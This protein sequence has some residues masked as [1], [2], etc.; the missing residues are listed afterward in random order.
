MMLRPWLAPSLFA[1]A[2]TACDDGSPVPGNEANR[3]AEAGAGPVANESGNVADQGA[4]P[5][6][7]PEA[8]KSRPSPPATPRSASGYRLIGTEPFWGGTVTSDEIVYSTPDNQSGEPIA[9]T[10]RF[11][12]DQEIYSGSLHGRPFVLTLTAGPRSDG[13]SDNVHAYT[14]TLEVDGETRRGCANPRA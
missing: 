3:Q 4:T 9:V 1:L 13:M 2:L 5:Q 12:G 8:P 6:P 11:E 7:E 14:A 10:V